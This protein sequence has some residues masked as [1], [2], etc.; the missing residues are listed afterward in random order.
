MYF[1]HC[2]CTKVPLR[3]PH[4]RHAALA[5]ASVLR[6]SV[7]LLLRHEAGARHWGLRLRG[8]WSKRHW[9]LGTMVRGSKI[10]SVYHWLSLSSQWNGWVSVILK[11]IPPPAPPPSICDCLRYIDPPIV[12]CEGPYQGVW[13][14]LSNMTM[15]SKQP[16]KIISGFGRD[17][18]M[19][20][21]VKKGGGEKD[22]KGGKGDSQR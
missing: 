19:G 5:P 12:P 17:P 22:K 6:R 11:K 16:K 15:N 8:F 4:R 21:A 10:S 2:F 3:H 7:E 1:Y 9:H 20:G 13:D 18:S 14:S